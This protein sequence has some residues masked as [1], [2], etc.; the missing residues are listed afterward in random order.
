MLST[1]M[2]IAIDAGIAFGRPIL[3]SHGISTIAI[4]E[5]VDAGETLDDIADDY[6]LEI[7]DIRTA[8]LYE[9]AA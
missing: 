4:V 6:G 8:V 5:R 7:G 1:A 2:P 3:A 9:R